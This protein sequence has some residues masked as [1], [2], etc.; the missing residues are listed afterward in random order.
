M[1]AHSIFITWYIITQL[2]LQVLVV[3]FLF[4][5]AN[6]EYYNNNKLNKAKFIYIYYYMVV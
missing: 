1:R 3:L 2:H 4:D 6:H 5:I